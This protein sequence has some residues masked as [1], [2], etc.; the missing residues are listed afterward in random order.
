MSLK[1]YLNQTVTHYA[2][3]SYNTYAE[4]VDAGSGTTHNARVELKTIRRM[5]PNGEIKVIDGKVFIMGDPG[6]SIDERIDYSGIKYRVFA[7]KGN[8]DGQG[9]IHH[10]TI[11]IAKWIN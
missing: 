4:Q 3:S 9:N 7:V 6:I 8:V 1:Q 10:T 5:L 2:R 11:E